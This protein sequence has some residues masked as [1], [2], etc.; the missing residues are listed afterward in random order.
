MHLQFRANEFQFRF[1]L[2]TEFDPAVIR[3][4]SGLLHDGVILLAETFK[5]LGLDQIQPIEIGCENGTMWENGLSISNFMRNVSDAVVRLY[6]QHHFI[7]FHRLLW[8]E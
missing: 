1:I 6:R 2:L 8:M 7:D 3:L 5:Q 4:Q